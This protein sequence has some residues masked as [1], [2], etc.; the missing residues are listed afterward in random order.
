[1]RLIDVVHDCSRLHPLDLEESV[2][3][4]IK[5]LADFIYLSLQPLH[6]GPELVAVGRD[7]IAPVLKASGASVAVGYATI[8][9]ASQASSSIH[10]WDVS[11]HYRAVIVVHPLAYSADHFHG[12]S[13]AYRMST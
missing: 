1:M 7:L 10:R 5:R 9:S 12:L 3:R 4:T 13:I 6:L 2:S 11:G 8:P